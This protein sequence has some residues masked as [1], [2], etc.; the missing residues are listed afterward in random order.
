MSMASEEVEEIS[1]LVVDDEQTICDL[2]TNVLGR[3]GYQVTTTNSGV[4][5]LE[6]LSQKRTGV[7]ITDVKMPEM[8]G[9]QL[10]QEVKSR[11]PETA[12]IVTTAYTDTYSIKD[13]MLQGADEYLTKPFKG[14]EITMVVERAYWRK[15]SSIAR[16]EK[17]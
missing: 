17:E 8:N 5:A 10:M 11:Y 3:A 13:A 1:I 6:L 15:K 2:L 16:S 7:V 12:I 14:P 4:S 9:F